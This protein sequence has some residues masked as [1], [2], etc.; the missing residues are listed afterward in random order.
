MPVQASI[1]GLLFCTAA[2][3]LPDIQAD[4]GLMFDDNVTRAQAGENNCPINP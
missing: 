3:G 2:A 1:M 4:A